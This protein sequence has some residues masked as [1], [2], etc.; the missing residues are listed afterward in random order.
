MGHADKDG[1]NRRKRLPEYAV[2]E[3]HPAMK[4]EING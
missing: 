1:S 4:I 3:V 2:W